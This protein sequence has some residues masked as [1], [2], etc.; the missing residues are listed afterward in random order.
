MR[1]TYHI[2]ICLGDNSLKF[3]SLFPINNTIHNH[4]NRAVDIFLKQTIKHFLFL[5]KKKERTVFKSLE[6]YAF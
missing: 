5:D 6:K 2:Q 1:L 4:V 3:L